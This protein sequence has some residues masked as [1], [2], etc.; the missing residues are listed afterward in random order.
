MSNK[1]VQIQWINIVL[2]TLSVTVE[3]VFFIT[4]VPNIP[5]TD[6]SVTGVSHDLILLWCT[7]SVCVCV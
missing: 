7:G 1:I 6:E 4:A 2:K 5:E 3:L